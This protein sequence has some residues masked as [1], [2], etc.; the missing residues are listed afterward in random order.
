DPDWSDER[1]PRQELAR[2]LTRPDN[3]Y[4]AKNMA[5]RVWAHFFGYGI[6]DPVDEPGDNTPPS[7]PELLEELGRAFAAAKFDNR[8]LVRGITRSQAYQ[9]SSR[10]THPS[11]AS[12]R[13]FARMSMKGL[14]P[15]QLFD[16]LV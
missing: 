4:F 10:L 2:W 3:P 6:P 7:H 14:T 8:V 9:L 16:S 13:S 15:Q 11:Q 1:S 12:G 5:N